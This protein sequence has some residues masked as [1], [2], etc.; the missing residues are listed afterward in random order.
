MILSRVMHHVKNQ[1]WT[2]VF[3]DFV[4]VVVGVFI[5]IQVSNW[6]AARENAQLGREYVRRL[7]LDLKVDLVGV[8]QQAAYYDE[9]LR[10]IRQ[11][12]KLLQDPDAD[13]KT[14]V[15]TAYRATEVMY[16]PPTQ[17]TWRQIVS[18]GHLGLLP[19]GAVEGG[20][21]NY[22]GFNTA[23]DIYEQL[24]RSA[25][26][27]TVR[28]IIPL[29]IQ[30]AIRAG[31]SD[32]RNQIGDVV[33]FVKTCTLDAD[34]ALVKSAAQALKGDPEVAKTLRYQYSNL[35]TAIDNIHAIGNLIQACLAALGKPVNP[36]ETGGP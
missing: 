9:V 11:A 31:C 1:Q 8:R 27:R 26:R 5:G 18:S 28:Q 30:Q 6:N 14:L 32:R 22:Y 12:D 34:P 3:L 35:S 13:P 15:T 36:T 25:Y 10:A 20:L 4:I 7:S 29:T 23:G 2:A 19:E 33:G 16:D 21:A 17:A 24:S